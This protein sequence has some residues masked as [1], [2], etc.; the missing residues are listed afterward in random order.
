MGVWPP[1]KPARILCE[2]ERAFCPLTP[3]PAYRPLPEPM[4]RP[5]RFRALRGDAGLRFERLSCS[6]MACGL[7]LALDPDEVANLPQHTGDL[8]ALRTLDRASDLAETE[9]S[10][11]A[12]MTFGLADLAADLGDLQRPTHSRPRPPRPLP[13][14]APAP[15]PPS[16]PRPRASPSGSAGRRRS[17]SPG[18]WR[19]LRGGAGFSAL[20]RSP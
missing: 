2:P 17:S 14:H 5:T 8:R 1:S 9:C 15:A 20:A 6:A 10:Q 4:P 3:R 11:R 16:P 18:P 7:L 12:A 19:P 13:A